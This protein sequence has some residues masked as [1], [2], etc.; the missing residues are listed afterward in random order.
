[1]AALA[2]DLSP[3]LQR[4]LQPRAPI[5]SGPQVLT[6]GHPTEGRDQ[7]SMPAALPG[8]TRLGTGGLLPPLALQN[9]VR[10]RHPGRIRLRALRLGPPWLV[11]WEQGP[12]G[13]GRLRT[14]RVRHLRA[15]FGQSW[16]PVTCRT[17]GTRSARG[18]AN[19][20]GQVQGPWG[21][22][23]Q[24]RSDCPLR[25]VPPSNQMTQ[26]PSRRSTELDTT[27]PLGWAGLRSRST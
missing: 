26:R 20:R 23:S 2:R 15:A 27:R 10:K 22:R 1:M 13:R 11:G 21:T 6:V 18:T 16:G 12:G 24:G 19:P 14:P 7:V 5:L 3:A 9:L 17:D 4:H 25:E 8:D